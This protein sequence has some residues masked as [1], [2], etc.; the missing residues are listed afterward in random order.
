MFL[1]L[2][3]CNVNLKKKN[4]SENPWTE[5]FIKTFFVRPCLFFIVLRQVKFLKPTL[6]S[7]RKTHR[8]KTRQLWLLTSCI[9]TACIEAVISTLKL[10]RIVLFC[11][12]FIKFFSILQRKQIVCFWHHKANLNLPAR[13]RKT[14]KN[15]TLAL[16]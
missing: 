16:C 3:N 9:Y 8:Y 2:L 5:T 10:S 13:R 7:A 12:I 6:S 1:R 15:T 4:N 14:K 11:G